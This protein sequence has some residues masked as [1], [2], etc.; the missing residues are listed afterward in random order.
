MGTT[1][2]SGKSNR[3]TTAHR[4]KRNFTTKRNVYYPLYGPEGISGRAHFT[5]GK[6]RILEAFYNTAS[7]WGKNREAKNLH[8]GQEKRADFNEKKR[9]TY[10]YLF[11]EGGGGKK[12]FIGRTREEKMDVQV[13]CVLKVLR[14][15][16]RL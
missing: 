16:K 6:N 1:A 15:S 12:H 10:F 9:S 2:L 13:E 14:P 8:W 5:G 3:E 11:L 4:R 7:H